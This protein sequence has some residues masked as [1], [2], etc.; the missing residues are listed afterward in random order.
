MTAVKVAAACVVG[1]VLAWTGSVAAR[2]AD[3]PGPPTPPV[4]YAVQ[5]GDTLSTIAAAGLAMTPIDATPRVM[6]LVPT[7]ASRAEAVTNL[8][9]SLAL[10]EARARKSVVDTIP[11]AASSA[12][13]VAR[14]IRYWKPFTGHSSKKATTTTVR[15]TMSTSRP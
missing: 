12:T 14:G 7:R 4:L 10:C 9:G 3:P 11:S 13:G 5:P 2:A 15:Q 6:Q 1:L 8:R